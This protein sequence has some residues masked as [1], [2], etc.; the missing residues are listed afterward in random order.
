M[1]GCTG[2]VASISN[3]AQGDGCLILFYWKKVM[4]TFSAKQHEV[5]HDWYV[6]DATDKVLGRVASEVARR[7]RGKHKPEFT[8][9]VDTGD[10]IVIVNADKLRVTGAKFEDKKYYRHSG[11][12]G[13]IYETNFRKMQER[14]PGRALEKAVKGML[15]KG[16]LGYAMIKKMKVYAGSEHPHSAQQPKVLDI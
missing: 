14:F 6:I 4:K 3:V 5:T 16:P 2:E 7:L 13:G 11:Y 8:P 1:D 10:F 15:P 9:H 12:P